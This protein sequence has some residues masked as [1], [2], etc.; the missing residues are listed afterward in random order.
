MKISSFTK[1]ALEQLRNNGFVIIY[2]P[3]KDVVAAFK[4]IGFDVAFDEETP[5]GNY[6]KA[7]KKLAEITT[8][9]KEKLRQALMRVSKPEV[10]QF[11]DTLRNCLERYIIKIIV[12]P[13]FGIRHSFENIDD[14]IAGLGKLNVDNPS[15]KFERFEVIV[16]Y[17]NNDTIRASF[18]T[19]TLLSDFLR[20][21][22]S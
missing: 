1:P 14:A 9:D 16:D 19:K 8:L 15:G 21:L 17:S 10:D 2:I 20:K 6:T 7:S 3:Y 11:M 22:G 4:E 12:I 18:Q 13:L 5:D